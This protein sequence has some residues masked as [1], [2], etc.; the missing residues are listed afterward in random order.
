MTCGEVDILSHTRPDIAFPV[1]VLSQF[2]HSPGQKHFE[3]AYRIVRHLK[4]TPGKGLLFEKSSN[5]QVDIYTDAD[6]AG[7]INDRRSTLG[8][9]TFLD[10]NLVTW[11]SK[12]QSVVARSSAEAEFRA[13]ANGVCEGL[14]LKRLL[15]DLKIGLSLPIRVF[16]DNK[17]A[18]S[19]AHNP[20]LYDR[21]SMWRWIDILS[22][23]RLTTK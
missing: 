16:C 8:I 18:V 4:G 21:T 10:E 2:M 5:L 19:V 15:K 22:R 1:S 13:L 17:A 11:R 3:A 20:V 9:C 7:C 6:W 12:K 14:W 23:R